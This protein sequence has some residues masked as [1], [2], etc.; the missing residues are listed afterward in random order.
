MLNMKIFFANKKLE[1][2]LGSPENCKI[3]R[4]KDMAKKVALRLQQA[5]NADS[6]EDLRNVPGRWHE[7]RENRKGQFAVSLVEPY[8]MIFLPDGDPADYIEHGSI[9]WDKVI[10]IK[11][12]EITDYHD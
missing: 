11:I 3:A 8:R 7:L 2:E 4:G 6:L 5:F 1:D 12:Q 10:A 9:K